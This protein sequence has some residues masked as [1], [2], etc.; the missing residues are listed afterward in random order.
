MSVF[1]RA[2]GLDVKRLDLLDPQPLLH[3]G[4]DKLGPVVAAQVLGHA[5]VGDSRFDYRND[6]DGSD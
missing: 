6:I 3:A 2:P 1:P 4:G 5:T